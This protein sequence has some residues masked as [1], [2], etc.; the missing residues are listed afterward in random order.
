MLAV[1]G[2]A[3]YLLVLNDSGKGAPAAPAT[4]VVKNGDVRSTISGVGTLQPETSVNLG[5]GEGGRVKS[6]EVELGQTVAAG[7]ILARLDDTLARANLASARTQLSSAQAKVTQLTEAHTPQELNKVAVAS[8]TAKKA[9][10]GARRTAAKSRA[11]ATA[12]LKTLRTALTQARKAHQAAI[13][14]LTE[15]RSNLET[16]TQ[17]TAAEK[18]VRDSARANVES[19]RA[20][21]VSLAATKEADRKKAEEEEAKERKKIAE[22]EQKER[23]KAAEEEKEYKGREATVITR[24]PEAGIVS[25]EA[26]IQQSLETAQGNL[27]DATAAYEKVRGEAET[28]RTS[29]PS[30]QDTVRS[31]AEAEATAKVA[32]QAGVTTAAQ[33]VRTA[34]EAAEAAQLSL[35]NTLA[36]GA[37]ETQPT[38]GGEMA[39]ALSAVSQAESN[40]ISSEKKLEETVLRAPAAGQVSNLKLAVGDVVTGGQTSESKAGASTEGSSESS[41]SE[42]GAS[43]SSGSSGSPSIVLTSANPKLF[44]VSLTQ[45][46]AVKVKPGDHATLIIDALNQTVKG[47][48]VSVTPLPAVKN[49]VVNYTATVAAEKLP[50]QVRIG[51]T[52]EVTVVAAESKNVPV[53]SPAALP[54][55]TGTVSVEVLKEGKKEP[56]TVELGLAGDEDVE[57]KKGLE[58]GD[59]VILPSQPEAGGP[60]EE[61]GGEE[62]GFGGEEGPGGEEGFGG[63]GPGGEGGF[64]E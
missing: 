19:V 43:S 48:L 6:V 30:L 51:M 41:S 61:F 59:Q 5:F 32:L 36:S 60:E 37:A 18:T 16:K 53:L 64:G 29:L 10:D 27:T 33:S 21:I 11:A 31:T 44:A 55:S 4:E 22:E 56:R 26:Q 54:A 17:R 42:G 49:G 63:E 25:A 34:N 14:R 7:Q 47:R 12:E 46:D 24:N 3:A 40:L 28:I 52:A 9:A 23:D 8:G 2:S 58:V 20:Q 57:I 35:D 45:A 62:E 50:P 1:A 39:E 13:N 15:N 38:R